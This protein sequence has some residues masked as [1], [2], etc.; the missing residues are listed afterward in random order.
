MEKQFGEVYY[1]TAAVL[2][3]QEAKTSLIVFILL[4]DFDFLQLFNRHFRV[5]VALIKFFMKT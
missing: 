3:A 1:L 2:W 5:S 4:I